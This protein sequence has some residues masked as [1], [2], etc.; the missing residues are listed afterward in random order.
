MHKKAL[1]FGKG[2]RV[3]FALNRAQA[4]ELVLEPGG[5]EGG[6]DNFH[7]GADQWVFVVSGSG[8]ATIDGRRVPLRA[9]TLLAIERGERHEL[10]N[11]GRTLLKLLNFYS[12]PAFDA[13]GDPVGPGAKR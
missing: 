6:P 13:Q 8:A 3:A 5:K 9:G 4:A 10:R 12:P 1:R 11:N 2:F 7:R